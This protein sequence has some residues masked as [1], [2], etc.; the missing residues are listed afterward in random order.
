[1]ENE[2]VSPSQMQFV[3]WFEQLQSL[4]LEKKYNF[5]YEKIQ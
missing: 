1:M 3:L 2:T 4:S 5:L